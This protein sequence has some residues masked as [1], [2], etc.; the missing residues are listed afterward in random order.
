MYSSLD[1]FKD[2]PSEK[3][4]V[5][6]FLGYS[7]RYQAYLSKKDEER[8]SKRGKGKANIPMEDLVGEYEDEVYGK[9]VIEKKDGKLNLR[10]LPSEDIFTSS[11]EHWQQNT[12]RIQFKDKFLPEGFVTFNVNANGEVIDFKIDLP[13]PDFHFYNLDF[14]RL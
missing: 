5:S 3:D 10:M 2:G 9:A 8:L 14:K 1:Q 7:K 6:T 4:W 13:N 12:Y 11:L